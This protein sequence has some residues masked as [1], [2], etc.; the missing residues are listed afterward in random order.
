LH[1][2]IIAVNSASLKDRDEN[3]MQYVRSAGKYLFAMMIVRHIA[4]DH[5]LMNHAKRTL[6]ILYE[7]MRLRSASAEIEWRIMD[8]TILSRLTV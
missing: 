4:V 1:Q 3:L 5:A 2:N 7:K 6:A 8:I